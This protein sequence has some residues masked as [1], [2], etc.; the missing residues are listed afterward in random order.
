MTAAFRLQRAVLFLFQK[1]T[2]Q[3][4]DLRFVV[5]DQ[6]GRFFVHANFSKTSCCK[7]STGIL[8]VNSA[9]LKDRLAALTLPPCADTNPSTMASPNPVPP[10]GAPAPR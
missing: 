10:G 7:V 6:R 9:P 1:N 2:Q 8:N 4:A 5:D 3:P